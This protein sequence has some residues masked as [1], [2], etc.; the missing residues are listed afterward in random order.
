MAKVVTGTPKRKANPFKQLA[1]DTSGSGKGSAGK[2]FYTVRPITQG[3]RITSSLQD[4]LNTQGK[5]LQ[6]PKLDPRLSAK[7][8]K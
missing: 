7:V 6:N 8:M 3:Q 5:A 4:A 2:V 1:L